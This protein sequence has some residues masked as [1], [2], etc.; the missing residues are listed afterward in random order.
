[1]S[2]IHLV[3]TGLVVAVAVAVLWFACYV[4]Y[5]LLKQAR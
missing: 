1:M 4:V 3:F 5:R 2:A